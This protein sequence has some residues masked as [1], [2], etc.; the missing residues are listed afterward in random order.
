MAP[1]TADE[2][3]TSTSSAAAET[4]AQT[5]ESLTDEEFVKK[6]A[7]ANASEIAASQV[8]LEK[9]QNPAVKTFAQQM[10]NDHTKAG[11]QLKTLASS[12]GYKV[13][14]EPDT[15]HKAAM[16][17]LKAKSGDSFD[18]AYTDQMRKDH[19]MAVE[20]F[21]NAANSSQLDPDLRQFAKQTLPTLQHHRQL[22]MQ[23]LPKSG[24]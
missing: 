13:P 2:P 20:L 1:G 3:S 24:G 18:Q 4:R 10:I 19:A 23:S 12:K 22:A 17:K 5:R 7:A 21:S 16:L 11:D 9:A 14:D 8:A 6:A 15:M